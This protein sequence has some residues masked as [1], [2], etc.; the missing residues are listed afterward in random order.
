MN[1][2]QTAMKI[3]EQWDHF[4]KT[5]EKPFCCIYCQGTRIYWNGQRER[6]ASIRI[7]DEAVYLTDI[8]CKRVKCAN[9][10]CK[11]SWTLRPPGLMPRRHYQL[12]IV[13]HATDKFLLDPHVTLTSIAYE[14]QCSRRTVGRWLNWISGIAEP[15]TLIDRL[16]S[17]SKELP[18]TTILM[19]FAIIRKITGTGKRIF[20]RTAKNFYILEILGMTYEYYPPGFRGMIE[21][22]I[23]NR[24][25]LTT[26]RRPFIPE[27]AR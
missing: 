2:Q 23:S 7:E 11:K 6:T 22:T 10:E 8:L 16:F 26:Y 21:T 3:K 1:L 12:C 15:P 9:P 25:R 20:Q 17:V 14:H 18:F 19:V 4:L 24:D 13:A 5:V 27:L